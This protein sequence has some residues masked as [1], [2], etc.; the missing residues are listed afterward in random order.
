[1]LGLEQHSH[2]LLANY[3]FLSSDTADRAS[4]LSNFQFTATEAVDLR[5]VEA[6][7]E[8]KSIQD[9][10]F[11][12]LKAVNIM[13]G[14]IFGLSLRSTKSM[15][16]FAKLVLST[17]PMLEKLHFIELEDAMIMPDMLK[18]FPKL[19]KKAEIEFVPRSDEE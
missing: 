6:L 19:S 5:N 10:L 2:V 7:W 9:R 3:F 4:L 16:E 17:A 12:H 14:Q 15:L 11:K 18:W 1:M 8:P 13:N